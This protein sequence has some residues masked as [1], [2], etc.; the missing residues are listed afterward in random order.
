MPCNEQKS[1]PAVVFRPRPVRR[2]RRS[3]IQDMLDSENGSSLATPPRL[4]HRTGSDCS[5]SSAAGQ[6]GRVPGV[7]MLCPSTPGSK[8]SA[9]D[10]P[11][12][13][14]RSLS[15]LCGSTIQAL[16]HKATMVDD[17]DL[18]ELVDNF[19]STDQAAMV[20]NLT[21]DGQPD[22]P[23]FVPQNY[24]STPCVTSSLAK[25]IVKRR[26]LRKLPVRANTFSFHTKTTR[27]EGKAAVTS[28]LITPRNASCTSLLS[29]GSMNTEGNM[30]KSLEDSP[31][32]RKK[33]AALE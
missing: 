10:A 24:V 20:D 21:N 19:G 17:A 4:P 30:V 22:I 13:P 28:S 25:N 15:P 9:T 32:P 29:M 33:P 3:R 31:P 11:R 5:N 18:L 16:F 2:R 7:L 6:S 26:S 14:R 27:A 12:R 8:S 1:L 23:T